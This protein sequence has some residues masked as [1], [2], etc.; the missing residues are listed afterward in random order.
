MAESS[1]VVYDSLRGALVTVYFDTDTGTIY[2]KVVNNNGPVAAG[3]NINTIANGSK[4]GPVADMGSNLLAPGI[5]G[6]VGP[7]NATRSP[8]AM[9]GA[10]GAVPSPGLGG[11]P[12]PVRGGSPMPMPMM[13]NLP[14]TNPA[15]PAVDLRSQLSQEINARMNTPMPTGVH[16]LGPNSPITPTWYDYLRQRV[17]Q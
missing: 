4:L 16:P 3:S 8:G 5:G 17:G 6:S 15:A 9:P 14:A 12:S 2:R 11:V 7:G 1:Y 13:P 10:G